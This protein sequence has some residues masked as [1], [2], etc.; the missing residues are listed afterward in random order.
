MHIY[1][2]GLEQVKYMPLENML[3]LRMRATWDWFEKTCCCTS[4]LQAEAHAL[5]KATSIAT[6]KEWRKFNIFSPSLILVQATNLVDQHPHHPHREI[7]RV[8]F[9]THN[10][11][12][13]LDHQSVQWI[14][15]EHRRSP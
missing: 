12:N 8:V 5:H 10:P 13:L 2:C 11:L 15:R 7:S 14:W 9:E 6:I 3:N 1:R 4:S